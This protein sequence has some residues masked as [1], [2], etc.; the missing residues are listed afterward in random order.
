M[1][2]IKS[3]VS[4][5]PWALSHIWTTE[6]PPRPDAQGQQQLQQSGQHAE[7]CCDGS[8]D[9]HSGRSMCPGAYGGLG[10]CS[11]SSTAPSGNA[12]NDDVQQG[13]RLAN[14]AAGHGPNF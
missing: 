6:A 13:P 14:P 10:L 12:A 5:S 9:L 3:G 11:G 4:N 1:G 2:W 7:P 8:I